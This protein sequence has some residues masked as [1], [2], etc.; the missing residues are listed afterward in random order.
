M[1]SKTPRV[2]YG[3]DD[4]IFEEGQTGDTAYVLV[5]GG[6]K[7]IK[8]GQAAGRSFVAESVSEMGTAFGLMPLIDK[9]PRMMSA[10][11]TRPDTICEVITADDLQM[12]IEQSSL[13][14]KNLM[15][16][17]THRLRATTDR[18]SKDMVSN[19]APEDMLSDAV[20]DGDEAHMELM[21]FGP[22]DILF[23]EGKQSQRAYILK[24]GSVELSLPG[25]LGRASAELIETSGMLFGFTPFIDGEPH[26]A[27]ARATKK[28][29]CLTIQRDQFTNC[30]EQT[31]PVVNQTINQ[32]VKH[33]HKMSTQ[34]AAGGVMNL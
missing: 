24:S 32:L 34:L 29:T 2:S 17:L 4:I 6:I 25:M 9:G 13:F 33:L 23:S 12:R 20:N 21:T 10:V 31:D 14:V 30:L 15:R 18:L 16:V 5:Q 19:L 28:T 8:K 1:L 3:A 27:T 7:L 22:G 26:T 11:A